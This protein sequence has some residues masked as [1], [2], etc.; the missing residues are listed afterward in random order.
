M[1]RRIANPAGQDKQRSPRKGIFATMKDFYKTLEVPKHA[2]Q[3]EIKKSY[4]RLVLIYH[5]DK[6]FG[7]KESEIKFKEVQEAYDVLGDVNKRLTYDNLLK[8]QFEKAQA[9]SNTQRNNA[10]DSTGPKE[11]LTPNLILTLFQEL[12]RTVAVVE[13][14]RIKQT[15]L[16][17][18]LNELLSQ[19]IIGFLLTIGDREINTKIINEALQ[20]CRPL[21]TEYVQKLMPKLATLAGADNT[22]IQAIHKFEKQ[23]KIRNYLHKYGVATAIALFVLIGVIGKPVIDAISSKSYESSSSAN[24]STSSY[25]ENSSSYI[26]QPIPKSEDE[27]RD[28][29]L[30]ARLLGTDPNAFEDVLK[31][32]TIHIKRGQ[33]LM[34]RQEW[35]AINNRL[36][37]S[38]ASQNAADRQRAAIIRKKFSKQLSAI[39]ADIMVADIANGEHGELPQLTQ[40]GIGNNSNSS[41]LVKNDTKYKLNIYY[42]GPTSQSVTLPPNSTKRVSLSSGSYSVAASAEASNVRSFYGQETL[43][44]N[45]QVSYYIVTTSSYGSM[46]Y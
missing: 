24:Y 7:N 15:A 26:S 41:I 36:I 21:D 20:C 43:Y 45:Y 46:R 38:T 39:E 44:G 37:I 4:R 13:K 30:S 8:Q 31:Q 17:G 10:S 42:S 14:K 16:F 6:T 19:S 18:R 1:F 32:C 33:Y 11:Q 34:A 25:S 28:S 22:K 29:I 27:I 12:R 5:P 3:E 2:S 40:T 23:H 9:N 35:K